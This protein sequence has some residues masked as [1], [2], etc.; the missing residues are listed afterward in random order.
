MSAI[1]RYTTVLATLVLLSAAS[2][3]AAEA[4]GRAHEIRDS[5]YSFT[6]GEGNHSMFAI[7]DEGVAV[8]DTFSS[9]H[10]EAMLDAIRALTDKPVRYAFHSHNHWDHASGGQVFKDA[11]AQTVM[12]ELAAEWLAAHPGRDSAPPDHGLVGRG[13]RHRAG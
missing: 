12:H 10:S 5:V 3:F 1:Q 9:R 8:F 6:L 11:G 13:T 7:G 2:A 4:G